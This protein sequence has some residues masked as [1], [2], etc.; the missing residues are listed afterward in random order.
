MWPCPVKGRGFTLL[1][2]LVVLGI[3][4]LLLATAP[5]AVIKAYEQMQYRGAVRDVL[6]GLKLARLEAMRRGGSSAFIV[7]L[8]ARQLR[9]DGRASADIPSGLEIRLIVADS[10]A[11]N[12]RGAIRFY[13][14]GSSTGGE[15]EI[16]RPGGG[17]VR[18]AVDWL[19]GRFTQHPLE[20]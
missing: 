2:L 17:G 19:L 18:I 1:E 11:T 6:T 13:S 20:S 14:D 4:G 7:D 12:S 8:Q 3:A 5:F 15:I 16:R 10:E 9:I